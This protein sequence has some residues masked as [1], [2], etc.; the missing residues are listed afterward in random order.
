MGLQGMFSLGLAASFEHSWLLPT[1]T[2][3]PTKV[4]A[5]CAHRPTLSRAANG[6]KL[7]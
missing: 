1:P 4:I 5:H 7:P 3:V 6:S 2:R